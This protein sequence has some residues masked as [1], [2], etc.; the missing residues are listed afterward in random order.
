MKQARAFAYISVSLAFFPFF[1]CIMIPS[2]YTVRSVNRRR[3]D[4]EAFPF[5][6]SEAV[7]LRNTGLGDRSEPF[8][9]AGSEGIEARANLSGLRNGNIN[10]D[11]V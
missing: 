11:I 2:G 7:I 8:T 6:R 1:S 5:E 4:H 10:P 3:E 9:C